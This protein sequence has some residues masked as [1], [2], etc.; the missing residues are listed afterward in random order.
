MHARPLHQAPVYLTRAAAAYALLGGI[1]SFVGWVAGIYSFTDWSGSGITMK[2]NA[3]L[4]AGS[5]G[6]ALLLR[7]TTLSGTKTAVRALGFFVATIGGLT[8]L[9]HIGGWSFGIDT[10]LFDEPPGAAATAAP[11]RMGPPASVSFLAIGVAI[12]LLTCRAAVRRHGVVLGLGVLAIGMLSLTGHW[13]GAEPMYTIPR[14]TGIAAQTATMIVALGIGIVAS[15]PDRQPMR[16][17]VEPSVAGQIARRLVPLVV[18]LPLVIGW[19]R[20]EGEQ[21]G[22]YGPVFGAALRSVIE[23]SV[24]SA[25]VWWS[26]RAI[27]ERDRQRLR[28]EDDRRVIEQRLGQTLA[29]MTDGFVTLDGDWRFTYVNPEAERLLGGASAELLGKDAKSVYP[30]LISSNL[31]QE[32]DRA[33][34]DRVM[35]EVEYSSSDGAR[36]FTSRVHPSADG[37]LSIFIQDVTSRRKAQE[38]LRE[39]DRRKDEFIATLAHELRNPLAPIR[40]AARLLEI[41]ATTDNAIQW[42]TGLIG[43]QVQHMARLLDD[44]LDVSRITLNRLEL[45]TE[46]TDLHEIVRGAVEASRPNI[47]AADHELTVQMLGEPVFVDG[48]AVRLSQVLSN[49]LNNAAKYSE[50]GGHIRVAVR[51]DGTEVVISV[52]DD[53]I[54]ISEEMLPRVFEMFV[55]GK[56]NHATSGLGIGL[57]LAKGVIERHGGRIEAR[58]AGPGTGSE[59]LVRLP[60]LVG[61]AGGAAKPAPSLS[62]A[63]SARRVLVV[64]DLKDNADTLALL[65]ES[66]G[67]EA[68]TAYGG[69][70][71]LRV[72][73][74]FRPEAVFL[75][76]GMPDID[77]FETCRR[78]RNTGWGRSA[79]IVAVT[80]WG[81]PHD[82]CRTEDAGFDQHL[83]K[84]VDPDTLSLLL[85]NLP[86][87]LASA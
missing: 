60:A 5:A 29:S 36:Y 38:A 76:I 78:I 51:L 82:R 1:V 11:G 49:I 7:T 66:L 17:L 42:A 40:N 52:T 2:A 24:L 32:L 33:M 85:E 73:Q 57:W 34:R 64:D 61:L 59:F 12:V 20:L 77:G 65:L 53:G 83:I 81:Q 71:A 46:W 37:G 26:V 15:N 72:G 13:Y 87:A 39:A 58:S 8:L 19:L 62:S 41:R 45:R 30:K 54:G 21:T 9:Q 28:A 27:Q 56:S 35:V 31:H 22:L 6:A 70:E 43:R 10:L 74:E 47:E 18:G 4:A 86:E 23:V 68:R 67:H 63:P 79:Y 25:F 80:G 14:L 55:Q 44:L 75:D 84:P 16:T 48:D 69:E 3:A 50:R